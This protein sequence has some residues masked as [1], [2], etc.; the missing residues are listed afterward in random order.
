MD[1]KGFEIAR[2]QLDKTQDQLAR[3]LGISTKGVQSFEQGWRNV[4]L[5]IERQLLL[6][7][8]L[9]LSSNAVMNDCWE[10]RK[11]PAEVKSECPAWEFNAGKLCWFINGTICH[12]DV[13]VS[14]RDKMLLCRQCEVF[15][16][17]FQ[18]Q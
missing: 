10:I 9:K 12:G 18:T 13:Q 7:L 4:P 11:C 2:S 5:H 3:L 15:Q 16:A 17:F 8:F 14:W 1:K 6:M